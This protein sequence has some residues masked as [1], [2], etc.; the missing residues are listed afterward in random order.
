MIREG[1]RENRESGDIPYR[2]LFQE[3]K[4]EQKNGTEARRKYR[5]RGHFFFPRWEI[6]VA[7]AND[8]L[9]KILIQDKDGTIS[10]LISLSKW[11]R[12]GSSDRSTVFF[13]I[14]GR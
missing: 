8:T 1:S 5:I 2:R 4:W 10:A 7:D 9:E 6:I 12:M 11:E 3:I 13:L 14:T